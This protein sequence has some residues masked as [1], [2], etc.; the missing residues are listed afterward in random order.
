[1]IQKLL[2]IYN[3]LMLKLFVLPFIN[4]D[5]ERFLRRQVDDPDSA[6]DAAAEQRRSRALVVMCCIVTSLITFLC[7]LPCLCSSSSKCFSICTATATSATTV[8]SATTTVCFSFGF[9]TK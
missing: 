5:R 3:R 9:K 1:M 4:V 7:T 2:D 8:V 6:I